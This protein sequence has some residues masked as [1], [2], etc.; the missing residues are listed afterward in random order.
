MAKVKA[1]IDTSAFDQQISDIERYTNER[2][3]KEMLKEYKKNTPKDSG[4]A[5]SRTKRK[6]N[7]VIGDYGYAGVLDDGLFPNPPKVGTG[8]TTNGYSTQA[9]KGMAT[10]T[11][12]YVKDRL[13]AFIKRSNK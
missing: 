13:E 7:S 9:T 8:K 3:V 6:G 12:E 4:N 5:R 10:P 2:L 11:L 1:I